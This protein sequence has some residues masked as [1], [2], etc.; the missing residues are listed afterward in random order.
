MEKKIRFVT[1][2]DMDPVNTHIGFYKLM[3]AFGGGGA[4]EIAH[5]EF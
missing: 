5:I 3:P 2:F 4:T 1:W